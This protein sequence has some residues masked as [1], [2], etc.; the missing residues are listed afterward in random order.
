MADNNSLDYKVLFL[1]EKERGK[2]EEERRKQEEE[3]RKHAE[4][5]GRREKERREQVES[6]RNQIEERTRRTTFLEFLRHCHNLLSRPLKVV[7]PSRSTTGT[8]PLPKGKHCPTRLRLWT[9]CVR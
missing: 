6:Q 3:R 4:D 1:Q 2:Q 8:I 9:D 5:E 7:T